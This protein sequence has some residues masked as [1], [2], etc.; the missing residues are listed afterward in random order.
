MNN[1]CMGC[2]ALFQSTNKD[3]PGF[4]PKEKKGEKLCERCF[5]ILH[6]N[7]LKT[8]D[9]PTKNILKYVNQK[10]SYA[11]F[12]V[13]LLNINEEVFKTY[14]EIKIP[15][16]LIVSKADYIPKYINKEKIKD[17]LRKQYQVKE[18]ILFLSAALNR[19]IHSIKSTLERENKKSGYLLGFTNSGKS[20]L[21]NFLKN[22]NTITTSMAP[23]TTLDY[24][25]IPLEDGYYLMDSPGF[26]YENP[27]YANKEI[28]FLK[29][30]NPKGF[31]KPITYQLKK[32]ASILIEDFIRIENNSEKCNITL[33]MS[34]LLD[35]MKV[36][37]KNE[38]LKNLNG[39]EKKMHKNEDLVIKGL[40]FINCK[41]NCVLKIYIEEENWLEIRSSFFER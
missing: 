36:Y 25:K 29:K 2:G 40:G 9:I 12:L 8:M 14:H 27:I 1:R 32:G 22:E 35:L 13:D 26:Q 4:I 33:Y 21:V 19:N 17:W 5:R 20:T 41:S 23:N 11:F 10:K 28:S 18:E 3:K 39:I 31:L 24:I 34:N 6:Y 38:R 15:K 7:D 37:E 16:T 30:L